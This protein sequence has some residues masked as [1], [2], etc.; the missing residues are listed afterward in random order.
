MFSDARHTSD[1][2]EIESLAKLVYELDIQMDSNLFQTFETLVELAGTKQFLQT[3]SR[4][5]YYL[6]NI[7]FIQ[8][9]G[10]GLGHSVPFQNSYY[11]FYQ[12]VQMYPTHTPP[13]P[14]SPNQ[15]PYPEQGDI[16]INTGMNINTSISTTSATVAAGAPLN[17]SAVG[18]M[19]G[20]PATP[21]YGTIPTPEFYGY[22]GN[23]TPPE[24]I[25]TP[26]NYFPNQAG[27][28]SSTS[29]PSHLDASATPY[30]NHLMGMAAAPPPY[31]GME[32]HSMIANTTD[33]PKESSDSPVKASM[34][35]ELSSS[36]SITLSSTTDMD[37]DYSSNPTADIKKSEDN[38]SENSTTLEEPLKDKSENNTV[39]VQEKEIMEIKAE[40]SDIIMTEKED[41]DN[42]NIKKE[43]KEEKD[44]TNKEVYNTTS[45]IE[46]SLKIKESSSEV[47]EIIEKKEVTSETE[48]KKEVITT[49]PTTAPVITSSSATTAIT[50]T[51]ITATTTAT[52]EN[53]TVTVD[54]TA[55]SDN[56]VE[57]KSNNT[58]VVLTEMDKSV[59][60][61]AE[62]LVGGFP[63]SLNP[64]M[65]PYDGS[66]EAI[67]MAHSG[68]MLKRSEMGLGD[69]AF[70]LT[71]PPADG[72]TSVTSSTYPGYDF[73]SVDKM[74]SPGAGTP[75]NNQYYS[76]SGAPMYNR[77]GAAGEPVG[78][79]GAI[80][81]GYY[82][83][84][85]PH[86]EPMNY[87]SSYPGYNPQQPSYVHRH[88]FNN[89]T[90]LH[91]ISLP[92]QQYH[93]VKKNSS[94]SSKSS[95]KMNEMNKMKGYGNKKHSSESKKN[96][97]Y[98]NIFM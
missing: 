66:V 11:P 13:S 73:T 87:S 88:V 16:N 32:G 1:V 52:I 14:S 22:G 45:T 64:T 5:Q 26:P 55:I 90:P 96:G 9:G 74:V 94:N 79:N 81:A 86:F 36:S 40:K 18:G 7:K 42:I 91:K 24:L 69:M 75:L 83:N 57:E 51:T 70:H 68:T 50:T 28:I 62:G 92:Q 48:E 63:I 21:P 71:P 4:F 31:E 10:Y 47:K 17:S 77:Y 53:T 25:N 41:K 93:M 98:H 38:K 33:I 60:P 58:H 78:V 72:A 15:I 54:N 97:T 82:N 80:S 65:F 34:N 8:N 85:N 29:F 43:I 2:L 67:S 30:T 3:F 12:N 49:K 37:I 23:G 19:A 76:T 89:Q 39:K 95:M 35:T 6:L 46:E 61:N 84:H 44:E 20:N 59:Y 27:M 56:S